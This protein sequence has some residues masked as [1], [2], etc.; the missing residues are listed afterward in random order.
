MW[1]LV[2]LQEPKSGTG[3]LPTGSRAEDSADVGSLDFFKIK[4]MNRLDSFC[5]FV[6]IFIFISTR[7]GGCWVS[8]ERRNGELVVLSF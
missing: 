6:G 4:I 8:V 5:R 7:F 3:Y 1:P 2:S